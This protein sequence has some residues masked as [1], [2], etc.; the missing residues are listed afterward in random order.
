MA[1][2]HSIPLAVCGIGLRLPGGIRNTRDYWDLLVNGKDARGPVPDSRFNFNGFNDSLGAKDAIQSATGYFLDE[3]LAC[4]DTSFFSMTRKET[5]VCDPQ[6]RQL[7]EVTREALDDAGELT[8]RGKDVG[9][10]V[11]TFGD[12][13]ADIGLDEGQYSGA[14]ILAG[15]DAL[16]LSNRVSY[17]FDLKGPRYF[18][19]RG[20]HIC[21]VL[22]ELTQN[23]SMTIKTGC[24]ASLVALHEACRAMERGDA[25]A[26]VVAGT[27]LILSP[28]G[29]ATFTSA[30]VLSPDA[31]C[32]TF[33]AS[34]DGY[35]RGEAI[36]AVFIKPL[37]SALRD[38]NPVRA[39]IRATGVNNDGKSHGLFNPNSLAQ[40]AL[41]R[42]VYSDAHLNPSDTAFVEV[43]RD[44][45]FN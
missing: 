16:M 2:V 41:I 38:G 6:Q 9:C 17:E 30:G 22:E 27:S 20:T 7:L 23:D 31:S 33:D 13:W 42:K 19:A 1:S 39:V 36:T 3:D 25:S 35:A 14:Y 5:E 11:G 10:Y 4:F 8:Y 15:R 34:A 24:S 43:C 26:A 40:E 21:R 45:N 37:S 29:V 32:K 44:L 28:N 18:I 12:S